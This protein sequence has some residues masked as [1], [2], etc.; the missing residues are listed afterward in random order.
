MTVLTEGVGTKNLGPCV[1]R[2]NVGSCLNKYEGSI[3]KKPSIE[4]E[5]KIILSKDDVNSFFFFF[6]SK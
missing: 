3:G 5:D 6:I 1:S 2:A 4:G